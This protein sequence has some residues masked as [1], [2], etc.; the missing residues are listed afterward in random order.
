[1]SCQLNLEASNEGTGLS[2]KIRI[3]KRSPSNLLMNFSPSPIVIPSVGGHAIIV[4]S[5]MYEHT[6]L[7]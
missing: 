4:S 6:Y 3:L 1:M 7:I 5:V 2:N